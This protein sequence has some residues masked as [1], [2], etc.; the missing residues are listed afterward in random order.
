MKSFFRR[1]SSKKDKQRE[2]NYHQSAFSPGWPSVSRK[3]LPAPAGS[4]NPTFSD[5]QQHHSQPGQQHLNSTVQQD[6]IQAETVS[7]SIDSVDG[8]IHE[9]KPL[10]PDAQQ[11]PITPSRE[12]NNEPTTSLPPF[13]SKSGKLSSPYR[14]NSKFPS[15]SIPT[16]G[17]QEVSFSSPQPQRVAPSIYKS[18][19]DFDIMRSGGA[20]LDDNPILASAPSADW[21][22]VDDG[23]SSRLPERPRTADEASRTRSRHLWEGKPPSTPSTPKQQFRQ[24]AQRSNAKPVNTML[25]PSPEGSVLSNMSPFLGPPPLPAMKGPSPPLQQMATPFAQYATKAMSSALPSGDLDTAMRPSGQMPSGSSK[26]FMQDQVSGTVAGQAAQA[27]SNRMASGTLTPS[28]SP[29]TYV[30]VPPD[31]TATPAAKLQEGSH[32]HTRLANSTTAGLHGNAPPA[33][34][35]DSWLVA[36]SPRKLEQ[37]FSHANL[38]PPSANGNDWHAVNGLSRP[39]THRPGQS[40]TNGNVPFAANEKPPFSLRENGW[41]AANGN[42]NGQFSM[43]EN[44]QFS[45]QL[46]GHPRQVSPQLD[47]HPREMSPQLDGHPRQFSPQPQLSS[48]QKEAPSGHIQEAHRQI[49]EALQTADHQI[50]ALRARVTKKNAQ[51]SDAKLQLEHIREDM[52][53]IAVSQQHAPPS[54]PDTESS[55]QTEL[56]AAEMQLLRQ[57]L[58]KLQSETHFLDD[59]LGRAREQAIFSEFERAELSHELETVSAQ[60]QA[61]QA[62]KAELEDTISKL[63]SDVKTGRPHRRQLSMSRQ[64]LNT[65]SFRSHASTPQSPDPDTD[66]LSSQHNISRTGSTPMHSQPFAGGVAPHRDVSAL[67]GEVE[68]LRAELEETKR[69]MGADLAQARE[70][71]LGVMRATGDADAEVKKLMGESAQLSCSQQ[72]A[73]ADLQHSKEAIQ[74]LHA[75]LKNAQAAM[76]TDRLEREQSLNTIA[77]LKQQCRQLET[78]QQARH[79]AAK[80]TQHISDLDRQVVELSM[81]N[82]ELSTDLGRALDVAQRVM[83]QKQSLQ[84]QVR[85]QEQQLAQW[86]AEGQR[87]RELEG[88]AEEALTALEAQTQENSRLRQRIATGS[89]QSSG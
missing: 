48:K 63:L 51:L 49:E 10:L 88:F 7:L 57:A 76:A 83:E 73:E 44:S 80:L 23:Q 27:A 55:E 21:F 6:H 29:R 39:T 65:D 37:D 33:Q 85:G 70:E 45:T 12:H 62:S 41:V 66:I 64:I 28:G 71:A 56:A 68:S 47:S 35:H 2:S 19:N 1:L 52:H 14:S 4:I 89:S 59:E 72:E 61:S 46:D 15:T 58:D 16:G 36:A 43:K 20:E 30:Q 78:D 69:R 11:L 54:L 50:E 32:L 8:V 9:P 74:Q 53:D 40:S 87:V 77:H 79:E 17:C 42:G 84:E 34:P 86:Q 67:E 3:S 13:S 22:T 75:A 24:A 26:D 25:E 60:L 81:S 38:Q 5:F 18:Y 82:D 31:G